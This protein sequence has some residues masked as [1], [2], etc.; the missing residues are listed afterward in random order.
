MVKLSI[1][2]TPVKK[3]M[4]SSAACWLVFGGSVVSGAQ[5]DDLVAVCDAV[6]VATK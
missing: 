4:I 3:S 5:L 6:A 1:M 2:Q